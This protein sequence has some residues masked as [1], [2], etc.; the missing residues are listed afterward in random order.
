MQQAEALSAAHP[1]Y[2]GVT[3]FWKAS[4]YWC[5]FYWTLRVTLCRFSLQHLAMVS[6]S[7]SIFIRMSCFS[8]VALPLSPLLPL[9]KRLWMR[10]EQGRKQSCFSCSGA[11]GADLGSYKAA[12]NPLTLSFLTLFIHPMLPLRKRENQQP[13]WEVGDGEIPFASGTQ[14]MLW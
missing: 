1:V 9:A 3:S 4:F 6:A 5:S 14:V 10:P 8:E 7:V 13:G 2:L 12:V 11:S